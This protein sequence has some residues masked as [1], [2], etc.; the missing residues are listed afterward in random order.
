M[1]DNIDDPQK[2]LC[3]RIIPSRYGTIGIVYVKKKNDVQIMRIVLPQQGIPMRERIAVMFPRA[4]S[5]SSRIIDDICKK[6]TTFL[7]G[8]PVTFTLDRI[9]VSRFYN[10]QKRVLLLER[11]IPCGWV[12][13]YGRLSQKLG[14]PGASRAVGQALARNPFP[15]IIPC[16]RTIK[17]DGSLGGYSGGIKLKRQLLELEGVKFDR[18]GRVIMENVW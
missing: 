18:R 10:F 15:I 6:I 4:R 12:S 17:S 16:H 7:K 9:D 1:V 14:V 2:I 13:T 5:D 11:K 3:Y 8:R